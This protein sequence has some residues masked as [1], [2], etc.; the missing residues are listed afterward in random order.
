MGK[1]KKPKNKP[2]GANNDVGHAAAEGTPAHVKD[3]IAKD[4]LPKKSASDS[5][6]VLESDTEEPENDVLNDT[7]GASSKRKKRNMK[8]SGNSVEAAPAVGSLGSEGQSRSHVS[9]D[10]AHSDDN[11]DPLAGDSAGVVAD[12]VEPGPGTAK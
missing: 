8:K 10:A 12:A 2:A 7:P 6:P 5:D 4:N 11:A 9:E 1:K 3:D